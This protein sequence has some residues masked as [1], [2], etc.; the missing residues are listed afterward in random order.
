MVIA[1]NVKSNGTMRLTA[2]ARPPGREAQRKL[3]HTVAFLCQCIDGPS[4]EAAK[5]LH[6]A[7]G[8]SKL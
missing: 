3:D 5:S 4:R 7:F 1:H 8:R 6:V 2:V